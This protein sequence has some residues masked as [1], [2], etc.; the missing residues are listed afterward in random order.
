EL[1]HAGIGGGQRGFE[2]LDGLGHVVDARRILVRREG[3]CDFLHVL[4]NAA[5]GVFHVLRRGVHLNAGLDRTLGLFSQVRGT[6][7]PEL[8]GVEHGVQ[9]SG[10]VTR[11]VLPAVAHGG[12]DV[13]RTA[14]ADAAACV[15]GD[16]V[17]LGETRLE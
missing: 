4:R 14:C 12:G 7:V 17:A 5:Q 1:V 13:V 15:T 16:D 9:Y 8:G 10:R 6:T 3:R 2:G 11:T